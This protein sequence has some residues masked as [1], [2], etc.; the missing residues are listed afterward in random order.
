MG[1]FQNWSSL[2]SI[3][4]EGTVCKDTLFDSNYFNPPPLIV[5]RR[6]QSLMLS[7]H[8][9]L[10]LPRFL[11]LLTVACDDSLDIVYCI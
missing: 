5:D 4:H 1:L 3:Y 9:F 10:N 2:S 6:V 7:S 11:V 8:I